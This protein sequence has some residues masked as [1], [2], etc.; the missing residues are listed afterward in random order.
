M[1]AR[2]VGLCLVAI[3]A[4]VAILAVASAMLVSV[5]LLL[6]PKMPFSAGIIAIN[7]HWTTPA[8]LAACALAG[9]LP[10]GIGMLIEMKA[11]PKAE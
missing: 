3:G 6:L 5:L 7:C 4:A 1:A 11:R 2:F 8:W 9:W 10:F